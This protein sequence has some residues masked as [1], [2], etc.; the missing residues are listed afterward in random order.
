M[1]NPPVSPVVSRTAP[2]ALQGTRSLR[3]VS[4][5]AGCVMILS[6][7]SVTAD[8]VVVDF[9]DL[10]PQTLF[11][12]V[13]DSYGGLSWANSSWFYGELASEPGQIYVALGSANAAI[14]GINGND[15][16]FDGADYWSR[17]AA[18][19]NGDFYFVLYHDGQ[20]VYD[21]R[22]D[23][24]GRQR[25]DGAPQHFA[26]NYTGPVDLVALAFDGGGDD[27]DHLAM[28]NLQYRIIAP[29]CPGDLDGNGQVDLADLAGVLAV[30]G[31][32]NGDANYLPAAD[33]DSD[34]DVDLADLAGLLALFGTTC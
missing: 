14:L 4:L 20:L 29:P 34:Q 7:M 16:F 22:N 24:A 9:Q 5:F 28:D 12:P 2:Q 21:G 27:W 32:I 26:P 33:L 25:F 8:V 6:S 1:R 19:A 11:Q 3:R 18:D 17:R 31:S 15:F 13:P 23:Q 30:F 10:T